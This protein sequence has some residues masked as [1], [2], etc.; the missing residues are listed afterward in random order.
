[1][2]G[3][4][5]IDPAT[6]KIVRYPDPRLR[7]VCAAVEESGDAMRGLVA[8]MFELMYASRGVGLAA[9]Q[10]GITIRLFIANPA[11][12]P[13]DEAEGVYINP[14]IIERSGSEIGEEGC[15]SFPGISC[16]IKRAMSAT[17]RAQD[18][19]GKTFTQTAEGLLARIFQHETDHLDGMLLSDR[20]STVAKI[21]NRR[22]LKDLV[23]EY[24]EAKR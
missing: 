3:I 7:E 24:D 13:G 14:E 21:A 20:M 1:M 19:N 15:L 4:S 9:P 2:S 11:A 5:E 17:V 23:D 6:F 12:E 16:K 22:L 8:R 10:V 18:M